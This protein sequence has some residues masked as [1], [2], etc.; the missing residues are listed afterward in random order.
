M[1]LPCSLP[2]LSIAKISK[3]YF[4]GFNPVSVTGLEQPLRERPS[5]LHSN[6]APSGSEE[7]K[8]IVT[9][10]GAPVAGG[11]ESTTAVGGVAS[12]VNVR[13]LGVPADFPSG[14]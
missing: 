6:V 14:T 2:A 4:A 13:L 9:S 5:R 10:D 12:T 7:W 8:V 11:A 1:A 3:W